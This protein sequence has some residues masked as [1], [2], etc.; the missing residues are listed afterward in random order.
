MG[1]S[2]KIVV[3]KL[4]GSVITDKDRPLSPNLRNIRNISRQLARAMK[5]DDKLRLILIHGGGSFGHYYAKKF[6]LSTKI[7]TTASPE[8]LSLTAISMIQLHSLLLRELARLDVYCTTVLP[9]ELFSMIDNPAVLSKSGSL[10]L[11]SIFLHSLIP[12]TFGYVNLEGN[13]SY[14]VS[15]DKIALALAN[16]L[17]VVKTIF[18][19]DVDGVH[20]SPDLGGPIL[21]Q[22]SRDDIA[23]KSSL[24]KFDVTG[25]IRSKISVGLD[26]AERGS[27]VYFVNGTKRSRLFEIL[28]DSENAVATK[29]YSTKK[30]ASHSA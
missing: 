28:Q 1:K 22:L 25:G 21:R 8:G 30:S 16:S 2:D 19:M 4:G 6:G 29:I 23:I 18:V 7:I 3:V 13:K 24:G 15:G 12:I 27:D 17:R 20:T 9:L 5:M 11:E 14:I 26:I 10:R